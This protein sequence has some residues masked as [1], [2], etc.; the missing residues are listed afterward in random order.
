MIQSK[1]NSN[2]LTEADRQFQ[3]HLVVFFLYLYIH[4]QIQM[5]LGSPS[6]ITEE[7]SANRTEAK[8]FPP[9]RLWQTQLAIGREEGKHG[10]YTGQEED[11]ESGL[12][13]YK[14]RYYDAKIGRFLQSDSMAFPNQINGMN[15]MMYVDG[16]PV[17]YRDPSGNNAGKGLMEMFSSLISQPISN[18]LLLYATFATGKGER[19]ARDLALVSLTSQFLAGTF[20]QE[21]FSQNS[22]TQQNIAA[23]LSISKFGARVGDAFKRVFRSI[24]HSLKKIARAGD[25]VSKFI[26][27]SATNYMLDEARKYDKAYKSA[28]KGIA[29]TARRIAKGMDGGVRWLISGGNFSRNNGNDLDYAFGSI[30]IN[31]NGF[32]DSIVRSD[33]G[34]GV[35]NLWRYL[36]KEINWTLISTGVSI[37]GVGLIVT[38]Y[39]PAVGVVIMTTGAEFISEGLTGITPQ[40]T[41]GQNS[42]GQGMQFFP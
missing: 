33:F 20:G 10:A 16:N 19:A 42:Q 3:H 22:I 38:L 4:K 29:G 41:P 36:S 27:K 18:E 24:D 26:A 12:I 30:G 5:V 31:T 32:Y 34:T 13:F 9:Q 40:D 11:R 2:L 39:N 23:V 14:A 1:P 8:C 37:I 7:S 25:H 21:F 15:R 35:T 28:A 17:G 6:R